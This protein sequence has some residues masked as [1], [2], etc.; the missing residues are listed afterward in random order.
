MFGEFDLYP[1]EAVRWGNRRG[2]VSEVSD[3]TWLRVD[4]GGIV[5]MHV[6]SGERVDERD[7]I[8]TIMN[9]FSKDLVTV[10]A[11][12]D[13]VV[14]GSLETPLVWPG[15]PLYHLVPTKSVA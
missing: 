8:C 6:D 10:D 5:E 13:G 3:A 4:E 1:D 12:F 14:L 2:I 9:P 11:P 15:N 7:S